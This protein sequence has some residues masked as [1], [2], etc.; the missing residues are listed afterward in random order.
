MAKRGLIVLGLALVAA[1]VLLGSP[2]VGTAVTEAKVR[3]RV[4]ESG[5]GLPITG[6][7]VFALNHQAHVPESLGLEEWG[8]SLCSLV[9]GGDRLE[10]ARESRHLVG[11]SVSGEN[12]RVCVDVACYHDSSRTYLERVLGMHPPFPRPCVGWIVVVRRSGDVRVLRLHDDDWRS[13]TLPGQAPRFECALGAVR[14]PE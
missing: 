8:R 2:G 7:S 4:T 6:A 3:L 11:Y 13:V 5:S 9:Q 12:G 14:F 10:V 1:L